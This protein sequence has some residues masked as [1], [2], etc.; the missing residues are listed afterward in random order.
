MIGSRISA[1]ILVAVG[2]LLPAAAATPAA[3]QDELLPDLRALEGTELEVTFAGPV[4]ELRLTTTMA[5][6]GSGPF[7]LYPVAGGNCDGGDPMLDDDRLAYQRV[8]QDDGDGVFDRALDTASSSYLAGCMIFHDAHLHWHF[9][10]FANY[11]LRTPFGNVVGINEKVS[12]CM[13]DT[14]PRDPPLP[15]QPDLQHYVSCEEDDTEGISV[16]WAD[17]YD[18]SLAGQEIDITGL[19]D[20]DYCLAV[21]ADPSN[22]IVESDELNNESLRAIRISGGSVFDSSVGCGKVLPAPSTPAAGPLAAP[23]S[24]AIAAP[25]SA[26]PKCKRLRGVAKRKCKRAK[27]RR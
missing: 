2:V 20:G 27:R 23:T 19:P 21:E 8:F 26:K 14:V 9:E 1:G 13:V 18:S 11:E 15:G 25:F 24:P 12:F 4:R 3:A 7:E 22:L 16:G 17:I 10:D 5:N 6:E